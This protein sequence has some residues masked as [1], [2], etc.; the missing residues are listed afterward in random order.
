M[1]D[2]LPALAAGPTFKEVTL[3][4]TARRQPKLEDM[5]ESLD[6]LRKRTRFAVILQALNPEKFREVCAGRYELV[7]GDVS[8]D[9][10]IEAAVGEISDIAPL[11]LEETFMCLEDG[12]EYIDYLYP[13]H[14]GYPIGWDEWEELH[15][16]PNDWTETM[17]LYVFVTALRLGETEV[18]GSSSEHYGWD[19]EVEDLE[20]GIPEANWD[21]LFILLDQRQMSCFKNAL[22]VCIYDTG[23]PY[24]DYNPYDEERCP[25]LPG[26][27]VEGVRALEKAWQE[28]QPI[29]LDH[30][31]AAEQ[32]AHDPTLAKVLLML[33]AE[34]ADKP[35]PR[36][37][38]T[39][40][41]IWADEQPERIIDPFYGP[42]DG[43]EQEVREDEEEPLEEA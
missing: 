3:F 31:T 28:A 42:L 35:E 26:I 23:N 38:Q 24:F 41:E 16:N 10:L 11:D 32:F 37:P 1:L 18:L 17:A 39:L 8:E 27:T 9:P 2:C 22:D 12:Y 40:A 14:L 15:D 21:R 7:V 19:L 6:L 34:S 33:W 4:L 25:D 29:R 30:E 13:E 43:C 36:R 20:A 5:V